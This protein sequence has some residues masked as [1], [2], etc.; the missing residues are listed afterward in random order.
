[1]PKEALKNWLEEAISVIRE[2]R[3]NIKRLKELKLKFF[4]AGAGNFD[5]ARPGRGPQ[6]HNFGYF[7]SLLSLL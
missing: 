1:M 6:N 4:P 5:R 2:K 3:P 7:S